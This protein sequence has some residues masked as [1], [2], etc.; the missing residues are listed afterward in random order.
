MAM[1]EFFDSLRSAF[2][3]LTPNQVAGIEVLMKA[4]EGLPLRHRAYILGTSWH[5]SGPASSKLHMTPRKEIWGPTKAQLGYEGRKDLGNTMPGD[6]KKFLGRGYVQ[7]TGRAN[8]AKASHIVGTDLVASPDF[9]LSPEIAS[10][11]IVDGMTNGW[12]TGKKMSDYDSYKNMRRVVNGTDKADL[13]AGYAE[14]FEDALK[15]APAKPVEPINPIPPP[16]VADPPTVPGQPIP[17]LPAKPPIDAGTGVAAGL[18]A[19]LGALVAYLAYWL[20]QGGN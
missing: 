6:G 17:D 18:L 7:I 3:P 9:A 10:K 5:E 13:I 12:F 4:T 14:K 19:A 2:G 15:M 16:V 11:I 1:K 20:T 8:Y